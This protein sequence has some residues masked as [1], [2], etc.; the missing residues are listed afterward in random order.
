MH[1]LATAG[2]TLVVALATLIAGPAVAASPEQAAIEEA[3]GAWD[4]LKNNV[5]FSRLRSKAQGADTVTTGRA[6]A[7]GQSVT[8]EAVSAGA[9]LHRVSLKFGKR[10]TLKPANFSALFG[11]DIS[12]AVPADVGNGKLYVD[13]IEVDFAR[14]RLSA[15]RVVI[16]AGSWKPFGNSMKISNLEASFALED[17]LGTRTI[18][19]RLLGVTKLP[20]KLASFLGIPRNTLTI[21]G[22]I[23]T[24]IKSLRLT[25][26]LTTK[27]IP[28]GGIKSVVLKGAEL[29]LILD[30]LGPRLSVGGTLAVRPDK[31]GPL[32]LKGDVSVNVTG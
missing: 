11:T 20:A 1:R 27:D 30:T 24:Q 13:R 22:V 4:I 26:G 28:L 21:E 32:T 17:P 12:G 6:K 10:K 7:F 5:S 19:V 18:E 3:M 14:K 15:L 29:R 25:V 16:K 2:A 9:L 31:G 8:L 23:D